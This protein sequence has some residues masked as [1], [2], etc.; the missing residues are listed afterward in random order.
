MIQIRYLICI[1]NVKHKNRRCIMRIRQNF[2]KPKYIKSGRFHKDPL[3]PVSQERFIIKISSKMS[4]APMNECT[5]QEP[6]QD[7]FRKIFFLFTP[8]TGLKRS[9][10]PIPF[11]LI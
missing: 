1:F 10:M 2:H 7:I 6:H 8:L 9:Q 11:F 5:Q 3:R 4:D